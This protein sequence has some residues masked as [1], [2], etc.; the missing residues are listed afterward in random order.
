MKLRHRY[1]LLIDHVALARTRRKSIRKVARAEMST[2]LNA[3]LLAIGDLAG[4]AAVHRIR[5]HAAADYWKSAVVMSMKWNTGAG[6]FAEEIAESAAD[7][8]ENPLA[9]SGMS[10]VRLISTKRLRALQGNIVSAVFADWFGL[11]VST[12][13]A[14]I[15]GSYSNTAWLARGLMRSAGLADNKGTLSG[16]DRWKL[17]VVLEPYVRGLQL[18]RSHLEGMYHSGRTLLAAQ[19]QMVRIRRLRRMGFSQNGLDV[20]YPDRLDREQLRLQKKSIG[21]VR[22]KWIRFIETRGLSLRFENYLHL[23]TLLA[24][25]PVRDSARIGRY[26]AALERRHI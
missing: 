8:T 10:D 3:V 24:Q 13:Q 22:N 21:Q 5:F 6:K 2:R 14:G 26:L 12:V 1:L 15:L 20:L 4:A 9:G 19:I 7:V 18:R 25:A 16:K 23:Q 17:K 11:R